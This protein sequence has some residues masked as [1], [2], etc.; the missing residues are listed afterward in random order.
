MSASA[1]GHPEIERVV[2]PNPGP[3]TLDGTNTYVVAIDGA[4]YVV[5]PGPGY[6]GHADAVRAAS[7]RAGEFAGMVLTHSHSDHSGAVPMLIED[8]PLIWGEVGSGDETSSEPGAE[9]AR[10]TREASATAG[11][12]EVVPTPGH[13]VDHVCFMRGRVCFCG[14]IVLGRGSSF[15][16]PD[17]GSLAAYMESLQVLR[18][19][20]IELLCPGHGPWITEPEQ[21]IAEYI[22]H[23]LDRE[24]KLIAALRE[25][26][27]SR[28]R[29]LDRAWDDVPEGLRPAAALVLQAH[30]EKLAAEGVVD[31]T[32]LVG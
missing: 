18:R 7:E 32:E 23:R 22:D 6:R 17:G 29:L 9:A 3:M 2:A 12:F 24:R 10:W 14:D 11:P 19:L 13:A 28:R 27:R 30:L 31:A 4:A 1:P 20:D 26:E 5:D 21:K 25:G 8:A 15:V 16:P